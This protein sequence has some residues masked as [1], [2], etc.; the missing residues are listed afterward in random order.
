MVQ[1]LTSEDKSIFGNP[2]RFDQW[3]ITRQGQFIT[4]YG[5]AKA[6]E[7][8]KLAGSKVGATKPTIPGELIRTII[9]KRT[10]IINRRSDGGPDGR[11]YD[12]D[13]PP[14]DT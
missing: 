5:A 11:G 7:F 3:N 6:A 9:D 10:I 8:A 4:R 2:W 1:A 14:G 12:G 13:L